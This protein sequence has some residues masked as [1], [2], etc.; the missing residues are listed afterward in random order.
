M[1]FIKSTNKI[2]LI[3]YCFVAFMRFFSFSA[4]YFFSCSM[5]F[6]VH[7]LA[8]RAWWGGAF[9]IRTHSLLLFPLSLPPAMTS[10]DLLSWPV[11][12]RSSGKGI[13][14]A[15]AIHSIIHKDGLLLPLIKSQINNVDTLTF[16]R[17]V[18]SRSFPIKY[19]KDID[20][21]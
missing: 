5:A 14:S 13:S 9:K 8:M 15:S 19:L 1:I 16:S 18:L 17:A 3:I 10:N 11:P 6:F 4:F 7:R 21:E 12:S 2:V 20:K